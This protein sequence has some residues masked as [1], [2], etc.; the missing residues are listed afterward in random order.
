M[1]MPYYRDSRAL[2]LLFGRKRI[3]SLCSARNG[4]PSYNHHT[5]HNAVHLPLMCESG[6]DDIVDLEMDSVTMCLGN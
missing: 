3:A 6:C 5:C 4:L 1:G 2:Q